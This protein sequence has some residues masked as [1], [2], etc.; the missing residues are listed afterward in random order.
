MLKFRLNGV[1]LC[2]VACGLTATGVGCTPVEPPRAPDG[3]AVVVG[4]DAVMR[5]QVVA[6]GRDLELSGEARSDVVV[7]SGD[8][9][10]DGAVLGDVIVLNGNVRLG[11][12]ARLRGDVFVLGGDVRA[13]PGATVEGR[14]VAWPR[15]PSSW[16]VLAE[17]PALGQPPLSRAVVVLKLALVLA[18][19][20]VSVVLVLGFDSSLAVTAQSVVERPFRNFFTGLV[21]VLAVGVAFGVLTAV[22]PASVGAPLLVVCA[23]A[24]MVCKLWG[25]VAVF[26]AAGSRLA[27]NRPWIAGRPMAV[28][29]CGLLALGAVKMVPYLGGWTW[30]VVTCIGI[31]AALDSKLGRREPWFAG[32]T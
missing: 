25:T 26:M 11:S 9:R 8:A 18:W 13:E 1:A 21:A 4:P 16:L 10:I 5:D 20:M 30:T 7:L 2:L 12:P 28:V 15:A 31:G 23:V 17:G 14:T 24:A 27:P 3:A 22:A 19:L 29:L 32:L 6:L